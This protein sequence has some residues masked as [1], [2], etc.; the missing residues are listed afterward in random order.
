MEGKGQET[1]TSEMARTAPELHPSGAQDTC[2]AGA[3]E[4]RTVALVHPGG[5]LVLGTP[6]ARDYSFQL[7]PRVH[8]SWL[9]PW[10]PSNM[11]A[12]ALRSPGARTVFQTFL[13]CPVLPHTRSPGEAD[14]KPRRSWRK[15]QGTYFTVSHTYFISTFLISFLSRPRVEECRG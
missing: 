12:E 2:C 9:P 11:K 13:L 15:W 4:S 1:A 8:S 14:E 5:C 3:A 7:G 6:H 10:M